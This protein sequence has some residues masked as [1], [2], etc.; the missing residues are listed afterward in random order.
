MLPIVQDPR[1]HPTSW[2]RLTESGPC[3]DIEGRAQVAFWSALSPSLERSIAPPKP[4][5]RA[6]SSMCAGISAA[7]TTGQPQPYSS[8]HRRLG[9]CFS[10]G[11]IAATENASQQKARKRA[12]ASIGT[13]GRH[14]L[15]WWSALVGTTGRLQSEQGSHHVV[16]A[17]KPGGFGR[18]PNSPWGASWGP[19]EPPLH[20]TLGAARRWAATELKCVAFLAR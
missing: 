20:F 12:Q 14:R 13:T 19:R 16:R 5:A 7:P 4:P 9:A 3:R 10:R 15:T 11:F 1:A 8:S 17:R 18:G 6:V 2:G